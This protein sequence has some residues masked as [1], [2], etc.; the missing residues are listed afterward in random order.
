MSAVACSNCYL[1]LLNLSTKGDNGDKGEKG[2]PANETL[3][4]LI[5]REAYKGDPGELGDDETYLNLKGCQ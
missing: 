5:N 2:D 4:Q 3:I 1:Y